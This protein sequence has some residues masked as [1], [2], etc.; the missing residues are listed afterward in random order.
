MWC[1]TGT[2]LDVTH[3]EQQVYVRLSGGDRR[4]Q[5]AFPLTQRIITREVGQTEEPRGATTWLISRTIW[6]PRPADTLQGEQTQNRRAAPR[7]APPSSSVF[8]F[9]GTV[10][11][12]QQQP[13]P[14]LSRPAALE[15][16]Q[17]CTC[18]DHDREF[19]S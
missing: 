14:A 15:V 3:L 12:Q 16:L 2:H 1:F 17:T 9:S 5:R 19:I 18:R 10:L 6:S 13:G 4:K 7:Q 8:C 11:A